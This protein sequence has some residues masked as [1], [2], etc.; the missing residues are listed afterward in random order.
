MF[1]R[2]VHPRPINV[3]IALLAARSFAPLVAVVAAAALLR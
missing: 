3:T 1:L 2:S